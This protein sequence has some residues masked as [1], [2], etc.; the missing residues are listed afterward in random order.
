MSKNQA[1]RELLSHVVPDIDAR[2]GARSILPQ[3]QPKPDKN[4]IAYLE[5][6][7]AGSNAS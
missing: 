7:Y 2:P 1:M 6:V 3:N 5:R 4:Y